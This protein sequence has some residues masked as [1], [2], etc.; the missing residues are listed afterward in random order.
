MTN[1]RSVEIIESTI[2]DKIK[3]NKGKLAEYNKLLTEHPKNVRYREQIG[4]FLGS[5]NALEEVLGLSF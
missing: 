4:Y 5:I 1:K 3:D 2:L